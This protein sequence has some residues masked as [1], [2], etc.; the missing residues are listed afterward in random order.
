M[1]NATEQLPG[2]AEAWPVL[3]IGID[4]DALRQPITGVGQ[5]IYQLCRELESLLPQAEFHVYSRLPA[6]RLALPSNRWLLH[7][8]PVALWRKLPSFLWLKTRGRAMC[9]RDRIQVFWAGRSLHPRLSTPV[10]TV[11][12]VHDLNHLLVPETMERPSLWS[13]RLWFARDLAA[14]DRVVTNSEGTAQR[15]RSS[16]GRTADAVVRPGT[17][18]LFRPLQAAEHGPALQV[19]ATMG[20]KPPYLLFVGT[21][22]PRKNLGLLLQ[23]YSQLR[24]QDPACRHQLVLAGVKGWQQN[25]LAERLRDTPGVVVT[26]FVPDAQLPALYALAD[27]LVCPS[28]Y[29]GFGMPV[30]EARACGTPALISDIPELRE[31]GGP[32]ARAVAL[33]CTAWVQALQHATTTPAPAPGDPDTLMQDIPT[34]RTG[35]AVMARLFTA[36][37]VARGVA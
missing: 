23:A 29:E 5:Y 15:L 9:L 24:A 12:T 21:L 6:E 10:R 26:G 22:E 11:A 17:A 2:I 36:L 8:E 33:D 25:A 20:V 4:G 34:W 14:A 32:T 7:Q 31:A 35:A 1:F 18:A 27:W 13:A 3:R 16:L 28:T 19:L 37:G 30:L